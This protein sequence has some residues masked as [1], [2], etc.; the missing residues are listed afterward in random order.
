[1]DQQN[2]VRDL[3]KRDS[4]TGNVEVAEHRTY[5][6]FGNPISTWAV[7]SIF[8]D[9]GRQYDDATG[10]Y[11]HL[12]RWRDG[13]LW[14]SEDPKQFDAGDP[15]LHR[16][17]G[18]DPI[19]HTDPDGLDYIEVSG[20][21]VRWVSEANNW[22]YRRTNT[23]SLATTIGREAAPGFVQLDEQFGGG[24]ISREHLAEA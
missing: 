16:V 12:N 20:G 18:N 5:S 8:G 11:N 3:V 15:N 10:M 9:Q 23:G 17:M 22:F 24:L 14:P 2:T 19:N 6:A 13:W 1:G 4:E 21:V 7:D